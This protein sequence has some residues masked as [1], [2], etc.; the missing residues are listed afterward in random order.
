MRRAFVVMGLSIAAFAQPAIAPST[1]T[2]GTTRGDDWKGYN[3]RNSFEVGARFLDVDGSREKYRSDVNYRNGLRLLSSKLEIHSKDGHGK[4]FDDLVLTTLGLGNDPYQNAALRIE[5]NNLYRYDFGWRLSQYYNP[6]LTIAN[7]WHLQDTTRQLQDHNFVLFPAARFRLLAGYSRNSQSGSGLSTVNLFDSQ[8]GAV[9]PLSENV[10]RQQ[11]EYRAGFEALFAGMKFIALRNWEYFKDDTTDF[12]NQPVSPDQAAGQ[13]SLR[14]LYRSQPYHGSSPGWRANLFTDRP[15]WYAV[16]ARFAWVN[17]R[18]NF[19]FDESALGTD[20]FGASQNRQVFV[21]GDAQRPVLS[22]NATVSIF[23]STRWTVTNH[24][25]FTQNRI[26]G[27]AQYRELDNSSLGFNFVSWNQFGVRLITNTTDAQFQLANWISLHGGFHYADRRTRKQSIGEALTEQ[28]NQLKAGQFGVR[29]R[30]LKGFSANFDGELGRAN[31]PFFPT[32][33]RNYNALNGRIRYRRKSIRLSAQAR[34]N[35]NFNFTDLW[36]YAA[37]SR[38]Y[39]GDASWTAATWF[40]F[41]ASLNKLHLDTLSGIAYFGP[42][43]TTDRSWYVS[44]LYALNVGMRIDIRQR[45]DLYAG[46]SRLSDA[47]GTRLPT[48]LPIFESAQTYPFLFHSP[49]FRLSISI[50]RKIRWNV[51]YQFYGYGESVL[52]SQNYRANTAFTSVLWS[53]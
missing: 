18:R 23:P 30:G 53:L 1:E 52:P 29:L 24:T 39:G 21:S 26:S 25:S 27:D 48:A 17:G 34:S 36:S 45:A 46:W 3:I 44:N 6:A 12:V 41:D 19:L 11:N 16:N 33:E 7:G 8:R 5:K 37:R 14:N 50:N 28:T 13:T 47:G 35:Y 15:R 20:R 2:V 40:S 42:Q 22:S 49:M 43:L 32:S 51:G 38:Q 4:F 9:F 31:N 10:R